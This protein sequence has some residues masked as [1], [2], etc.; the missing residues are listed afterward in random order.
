MSEILLNAVTTELEPYPMEE[1]SKIR[2]R[3]LE[4]G[5]N[6]LDF[7]TGDPWLETP[8]FIREALAQGI[9]AFSRYPSVRGQS[10]LLEAHEGYLKRRIGVDPS[11]L[12]VL[13]TR[14]S[15][16]AIFHIGLSVVGQNG[17]KTIAYPVP[18]Y[19]VY[20]ASVKFA[21]GRP[22]P[23]SLNEANDYLMDPWNWD[24]NVVR[25]LA[26]VW[27]NYPHNPTG[28]VASRSY[29]NK[30]VEW[31]QQRD[32]VVLADE[33]Y[34]DIYDPSLSEDQRPVSVLSENTAGVVSF[35][36]LSKRSGM[37]GY[38]AGFMAGDPRL[39]DAH[40]KARARFGLAQPAFIQ[41]AAAQAWIDDEHVAARRAVFGRRMSLLGQALQSLSLIDEI[42]TATFYL[43]AKLPE[44]F[45]GDDVQFCRDLADSKAILVSPASWLGDP[46]AR[47]FRLACVPD[48]E[49]TKEAISGLEEFIRGV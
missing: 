10:A 48:E 27:I 40:S 13:P 28:V 36:S 16:E 23:V 14:G 7:G 19:P 30:L 22:Y 35:M 17:K 41:S 12:A 29:L 44:K 38:R 26:A 42:P 8:E 47:R 2:S 39:L 18:G 25:D 4:A 33:C 15:K 45:Q 34:L 5:R 20:E 37:T 11:A 31:C 6:V 9:D 32:I 1:L 3:L 46:S 24:A 49:Q 21:G 43:W